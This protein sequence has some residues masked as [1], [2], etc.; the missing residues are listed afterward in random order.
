MHSGSTISGLL[1]SAGA[2]LR[3]PKT[4]WCLGIDTGGVLVDDA[5]GIVMQVATIAGIFWL[6]FIGRCI[7]YEDL[8]LEKSITGKSYNCLI[9]SR[10]LS[11]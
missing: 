7:T 8:V 9:K 4:L 1:G 5:R 11:F 3:D 6:C 2:S 10:K